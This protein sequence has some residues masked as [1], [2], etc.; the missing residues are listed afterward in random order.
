MNRTLKIFVFDLLAILLS[1]PVFA[2]P[3]SDGDIDD[4]NQEGVTTV[5]E[6]NDV[7]DKAEAELNAPQT[8]DG[9]S[10][11]TVAEAPGQ[12]EPAAVDDESSE[13]TDE[14]EESADESEDSTDDDA[15]SDDED[16]TDESE[17]SDDEDADEDSGEDE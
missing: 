13:A 11:D 4:P 2:T 7:A 9:G 12:A 17:D 8:Q 14:S 1:A 15:G 6:F 16:S 5:K 3:E 10:G